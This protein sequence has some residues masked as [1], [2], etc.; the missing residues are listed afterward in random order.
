MVTL[1]AALEVGIGWL[2]MARRSSSPAASRN[3]GLRLPGSSTINSS[4]PQRATQAP[5]GSAA[6]RRSA[7]Q[8]ITPSPATWPKW[9][10][11][12]IS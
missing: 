3:P 12:T 2:E 7:T 5:S 11:S 1:S 8:V 4:P 10:C 6:R 9:S